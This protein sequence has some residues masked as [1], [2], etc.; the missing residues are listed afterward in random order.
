MKSLFTIGAVVAALSLF[1]GLP[2]AV[3]GGRSTTSGATVAVAKTGL[4]RVLVDARGRTL[5]LFEKDR[6]GRSAC[7]GSCAAA[8]PPL[9]TSGKPRAAAGVK[10]SLLGIT[11]RADSRLQVTYNHHPL[12]TFVKDTRKGQTTGENVYAFG[13]EWY[14]VSAAGAAIEK[15]AAPSGGGGYGGYGYRAAP[16]KPAAHLKRPKLRDGV[17]TVRGTDRDDGIVLRL[18]PGRPAILDV[19]ADN[20]GSGVFSFDRAAITSITVDARGGDDRVRIDELGGAFTDTIR[21]TLDGGDGDDTL[22]GGSGV[23]TLVGGDGNDSIDGNRGNDV[24]SLGAGDDTFVWDPGDG[25]DVVEGDDGAD[26][27][28]FNGANIAEHVDLSS[29]GDRLRFVR[30][31]ASITMDTHAVEQVDFNALGGADVVTTNDL[32]G[33]GVAAVNVDVGAGDGQSDV[34]VVRGTAGDDRIFASGSGGST[35]VTGLAAAVNVVHADPASDTLAIEALGGADAVDAPA[36]A[37]DA[38]KLTIDGGTANDRL[39][40]GAGNDSIDGGI[41]ADAAFLGP[42][43]DT[44]VWDPGEGSDTVEGG[45]GAD[46]MRFNGANIAE[47]VDLTANGSRLRFFRDIGNITMD[48]DDVEQVDFDALGGADAVTV[49]DLQGTDVRKVNVDLGANGAGDGA[50][51]SIVVNATAG[52]DAIA[53][54]GGA[55]TADVT[56]LAAA[57]SIINAEP[58]NDALAIDAKEGDDVVIAAGLAATSVKLTVDGNNGDDVV[59]GSAGNDTLL[60]G[61]GDDTLI[62]GPG[63]DVLDGGPGN[64]TLLQ[65]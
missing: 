59:V 8:W 27:M 13:A 11:K 36:L 43:D 31:V 57:V 42:G 49:N 40:G 4:G 20:G 29:N 63:Q 33:T 21:T 35:T 47:R 46:T 25:S 51:D 53:V 7:A 10:A 18:Q 1:V 65:D 34:V 9:I 14:V 22:A 16:P 28:L 38:V 5:Y 24:S 56:G 3:A 50:S 2:G 6:R 26:T 44:F 37:A 23:E 17:L 52:S 45:D 58:T 19:A 60:G 62:G 39:V 32:T 54:A 41:G 15:T 12:Y 48:T 64:N 30:D 55:G 61:A